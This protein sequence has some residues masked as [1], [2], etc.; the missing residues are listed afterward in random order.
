[1]VNDRYSVPGFEFGP[2]FLDTIGRRLMHAGKRVRISPTALKLLEIL[3][4]K[5]GQV[6]TTK[7]LRIR[8]WAVNPTQAHEPFQDKNALFIAVRKLKEAL[9]DK[10]RHWIV[11]VRSTGYT[12]SEEVEIKEIAGPNINL[13]QAMT[14]FIGR[15][16]EIEQIQDLLTQTRLLT[17]NGP[18]GI[19]KTRLAIRAAA[20]IENFI[21]GIYLIDLSTIS[22]DHLVPRAVASE[23]HV[24]EAPGRHVL[25][26]LSAYLKNKE[27]LLILDNCEHLIASAAVLAENLLRSAS[28]LKILVTS[29][30]PLDVLGETVLTIQPLTIPKEEQ[31]SD[32][33]EIKNYEAVELFIELAKQR[34]PHFTLNKQNVSVVAELCRQLEGI[35]LAIEL[36]AA[37]T[38]ALRV[39]QILLLMTDRFKLLRRSKRESTR[40]QTLESAIDWSYESLAEEEKFL[41]RR[42]SIF[43][44]GWTNDAASKICSSAAINESEILHLLSQL[45]RK[46]LVTLDEREGHIRYRMLEMIRQYSIGK[47]KESGD[48]AELADRHASYFVQLSEQAF[49]EGARGD[50]FDRLEADNSNLRVALR[51][52]I[53]QGGNIELGLRLCGALGRFWFIRGH[54]NEATQWTEKALELDDGK[55]KGARA[56]ALR[57]GGFFFGQMADS[58]KDAERGRACFEESITIWK[59][60]GNKKELAR[61]LTNYS[62]LLNRQGNFRAATQAIRESLFIFNELGDPANIAP[63]THNLALSLLDQG[64]YEQSIPLFEE[65]LEI[66]SEPGIDDEYLQALCLHNLGEAEF[67]RGDLDVSELRLEESLIISEELGHRSLSARTAIIQG[68]VAA[69]RGDYKIALAK[70]RGALTEMKTIN[71][72]QGLIDALE[73][74]A[75]TYSLIGNDRLAIILYGSAQGLRENSKIF[76]GPAR[77]RILSQCVNSAIESLGAEKARQLLSEAHECDLDIIIKYAM[78]DE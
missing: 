35:P 11:N 13:P 61:T 60:L 27:L 15:E 10:Y 37:R 9:G 58:D 78:E 5:R 63:A 74:I 41:I 50:W 2:F 26:T 28:G 65:C 19:G 34:N 38:D 67:Q 25:D 66:A 46:S 22:D 48:T 21:D 52:T 14:S 44:G 45:V 12:I 32:V 1:M 76:L 8:V 70:Q 16:Y 54:N 51:H 73:A 6:V 30:E 55:F 4:R 47:L 69:K 17:L 20:I 24:N 64:D 33:N 39:E 75:C 71:D 43:V 59:E 31:Q 3:L 77:Q 40:H 42:L 56:K 18:P 29:R 72:S 53:R 68:E 62:F 7:E 36:A 23:L 49:E 57:T